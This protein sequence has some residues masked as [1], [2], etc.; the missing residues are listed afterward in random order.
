MT[1]HF[2][3]DFQGATDADR[4]AYR[5]VR[6][7]P[8]GDR[9]TVGRCLGTVGT[10][11]GTTCER[12]RRTRRRIPLARRRWPFAAPRER[13]DHTGL[14]LERCPLIN[15]ATLA[16]TVHGTGDNGFMATIVAIARA[17]GVSGYI[18]D[19]L[20]RWPAIH[21]EDAAHL[22]RL[23]LENGPARHHVARDERRGCR[24]S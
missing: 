7:H 8:R 15:T 16:P 24:P 2:P 4:R 11:P 3:G 23:A 13:G 6:R 17:T 9:A 22:F 19:G 10:G 18:N 14:R 1:S 20:N 21:R 12:R 5:D